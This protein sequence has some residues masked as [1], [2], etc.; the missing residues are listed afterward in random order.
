V[1]K[2]RLQRA[3]IKNPHKAGEWNKTARSGFIANQKNTR[4]E[5]GLGATKTCLEAGQ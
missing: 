4:M 1:K 3:G 5:A 2:A